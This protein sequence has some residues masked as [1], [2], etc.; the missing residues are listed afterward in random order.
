MSVA[1]GIATIVGMCTLWLTSWFTWARPI[2]VTTAFRSTGPFALALFA[3]AATSIS[4]FA[5]LKASLSRFAFAFLLGLMAVVLI[6]GPISEVV[7]CSF[8]R[9]GCINL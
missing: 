4:L 3:Y 9:A 5:N 6:G 8:D 7:H 2:G 1:I